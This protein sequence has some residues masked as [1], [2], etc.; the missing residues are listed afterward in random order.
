MVSLN[1]RVRGD[2]SKPGPKIVTGRNDVTT[3]ALGFNGSRLPCR[4]V[5][6]GDILYGTLG[7]PAGCRGK[8]GVVI[9]VCDTS[10][11]MEMFHN[12]ERYL[13]PEFTFDSITELV[14]ADDALG[15]L[16]NESPQHPHNPCSHSVPAGDYPTDPRLI[17]TTPQD[18]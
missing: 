11:I 13:F 17:D 6:V 14:P 8:K 5:K 18:L 4:Y 10:I 15:L 12:D 3:E 1:G 7:C 9:S 16:R 2:L